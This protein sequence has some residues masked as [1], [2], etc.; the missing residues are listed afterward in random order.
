RAEALAESTE[1][2]ATAEEIKKL[3]AEWKTI[4]PVPRART[5][6]LWDRFRKPC[7]RFFT[8]RD[9][10]RQKRQEEWSANQAKKE[11][12]CAQAEALASSSDWEAGLA[13]VKRLQAEWKSV[14][15]VKKARSEALWQRFR[16]AGDAFYERYKRRDS[17]AREA[18][19]AAREALCAELEALVPSG[20][21]EAIPDLADKV[22]AL[23]A[24]W[25]QAAPL[26]AADAAALQTRLRR[27][28]HAI[29]AAAPDRFRGTDYDP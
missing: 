26:A 21:Q 19:K 6:A 11:A 20:G 3:Q 4:G 12:L 28:L 27:A 23:A 18:Q 8:R 10:S 1:W 13:E 7:D 25:R 9:E 29:V 24:S 14:G 22:Q 17:I 5:K 2:L 15:A 16:T